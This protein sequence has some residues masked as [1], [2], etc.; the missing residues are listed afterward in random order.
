MAILSSARSSPGGNSRFPDP[1]FTREQKRSHAL[2]TCPCARNSR[3]PYELGLV[4]RLSTRFLRPCRAA[5]TIFFSAWR[6]RIP[7][8]F[9]DNSTSSSYRTLKDPSPLSVRL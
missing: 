6:R 7:G 4:Q 8:T 5:C 3:R 2:P 9:I 1:T